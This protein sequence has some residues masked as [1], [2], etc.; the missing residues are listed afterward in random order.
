MQEEFDYSTES[1]SE[2]GNVLG[3]NVKFSHII[4]FAL[5]ASI[6]SF[7]SDIPS[8]MG[9]IFTVSRGLLIAMLILSVFLPNKWGIP[10][11]LILILVGPDSVQTVTEKI[12]EGI[13]VVASVWR[14]QFGPVNP[15]WI[16]TAVAAAHL[17][18]I[19]F[20][21]YLDKPVKR[22]LLWFATVPF[23]TGLLYGGFISINRSREF[24]ID[25]RFPLM[26]FIAILLFRCFFRKYPA[27]FGIMLSLFTG[28]LI[29]RFTCFFVYWL[30]EYNPTYVLGVNRV[31]TDS[32]KSSVIF[33]MLFGMYL[34]V[35]KKRIFIGSSMVII[36][37][38]LLFVFATRFNWV[39][40]VVC[41]A[42]MMY[43]LGL[44]RMALI[45][46]IVIV[47]MIS[48]VKIIS[49]FSPETA[50]MLSDK[51]KT[52]SVKEP[53]NFLEQI[54][55]GRYA[56]II[57]STYT[58]ARHAA[59][60]W[61][62]GY[63]SYYTDDIVPFGRDLVTMFSERNII[64]GQFHFIHNSLFYLLFKFGLVG[65]FFVLVVWLWPAWKCRH[66]FNK[67]GSDL[68]NGILGC[69]IAFSANTLVNLWWTGKGLLISGFVIASLL[70]TLDMREQLDLYG[71]QEE[72]LSYIE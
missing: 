37:T 8:S 56:Q 22:A 69:F 24:V 1:F 4:V 70:T 64:T 38:L 39:M 6:T 14:L 55:P 13:K 41:C 52:M 49:A 29:S 27:S 54:D 58:T 7:M 67:H 62:N 60:L 36:S 43:L 2:Q 34:I 21:I 71:E 65:T 10:L 19:I 18:K 26:F 46:P 17:L 44:A 51:A 50:L 16:I 32:T 61:G 11:F 31:T 66:V 5:I 42:I 45:L 15:A 59:F 57:N 63:A 20:P 33:L 3:V 68:F 47:L 35:K 40:V 28:V 9:P 25:I 12:T 23:F 48:S 72:M 30:T 53:G